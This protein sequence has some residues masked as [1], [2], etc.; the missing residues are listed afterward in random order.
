VAK[1]FQRVSDTIVNIGL[2]TVLLNNTGMALVSFIT[3]L[4]ETEA[5]ILRSES[6]N[7]TAD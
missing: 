4:K 2:Y 7:G 1:T 5:P 3:Y 6:R